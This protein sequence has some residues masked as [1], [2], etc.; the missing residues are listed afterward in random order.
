MTVAMHFVGLWCRY[1]FGLILQTILCRRSIVEHLAVATVIEFR[2]I[3]NLL[4]TTSYLA[5][6][7]LHRAPGPQYLVQ[8]TAW[9]R[10]MVAEEQWEEI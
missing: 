3:I 2:Q 4:T 6:P 10:A 1:R 8:V 5:G 9:R 7:C